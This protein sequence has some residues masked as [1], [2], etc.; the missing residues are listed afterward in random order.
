[1]ARLVSLHGR[2][3]WLFPMKKRWIDLSFSPVV[4]I[5]GFLAQFQFKAP[6]VFTYLS[7]FLYFIDVVTFFVTKCSM[8]FF[9]PCKQIHICV[10]FVRVVFSSSSPL[11]VSEM[12]Y[13]SILKKKERLFK[14][15]SIPTYIPLCCSLYNI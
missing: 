12:F 5:L 9:F 14:T 8:L 2:L 1:M 10:D 15:C 6:E 4:C 11:P 13:W 3:W 7:L